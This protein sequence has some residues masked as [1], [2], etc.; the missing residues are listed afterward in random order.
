MEAP[1]FS[2][3]L[4]KR[5]PLI[6]LFIGYFGQSSSDS[7]GNHWCGAKVL[8]GGGKSERRLYLQDC[9]DVEPFLSDYLDKILDR[10]SILKLEGHL[11]F[12]PACRE[13]LASMHQV[14]MALQSLR[15]T[16]SPASFKLRLSNRLQEEAFRERWA[17]L[18]PLVCGFALATALAILLW[19]AADSVTLRYNEGPEW[20]LPV[21]S[22]EFGRTWID[23]F[24]ELAQ[25]SSQFHAQMHSV[26]F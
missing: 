12:C 23:R 20:E 3:R 11:R 6:F 7:H 9:E 25:S 21:S 15:A 16:E 19:P 22:R 4:F 18:R 8:S 24:P 17:W 10:S 13:V 26:S 5:E 2:G 1:A 14:R